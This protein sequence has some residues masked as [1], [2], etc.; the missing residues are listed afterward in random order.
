MSNA[1][2]INET[3]DYA[4]LA[5][6]TGQDMGMSSGLPRLRA[7]REPQD[8][9]GNPLPLG[10]LCVEN[11]DGVTVY[12]AEE[13][14]QGNRTIMTPKGVTFRPF[15]NAYQYSIYDN[16][17]K[18]TVN[19]SIIFTD[20]RQDAIDEKGTNK[21]GKVTGKAKDGLTQAQKAAN[22]KIK[23][24]RLVFGLLKGFT[25][26]DAEGNEVS[27]DD[28][29]VVYKQGGN[30]FMAFDDQVLKTL[31][32]MKR[33]MFLHELGLTTERVA[34]TPT[35]IGY[36]PRYTLDVTKSVSATADD[37]ELFRNF[38]DYI[39]TINEGIQAK[40]AA[41]MK[42]E[43]TDADIDDMKTINDLDDDFNDDLPI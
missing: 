8:D 14:K 32:K 43:T 42:G 37:M 18:E 28:T 20:H 5:A 17:K 15:I 2:A 41:A 3:M 26:I 35:V 1:L 38:N 7:N 11:K 21:C 34:H 30:S 31:N 24:A 29:P 27:V 16:E 40:A 12:A 10:A 9:K 19:R 4:T 23:C 13:K 25:G 39:R 6:L 33:P 22:D 36:E